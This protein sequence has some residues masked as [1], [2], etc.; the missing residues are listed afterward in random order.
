[1]NDIPQGKQAVNCLWE[2]LDTEYIRKSLQIV[3]INMFTE[4][5]ETKNKE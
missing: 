3:I 5:K 1:M 4:L 2:W